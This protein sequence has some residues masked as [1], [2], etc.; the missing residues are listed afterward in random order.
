MDGVKY[1]TP[2]KTDYTIYTMSK[3]KY[4]VMAK[5]HI[6]AMPVASKCININCDKF[7]KTCRDRDN[8]FKF[9]KQYTII[10]YFYFPMIFKN[11][12]FIGGLKELLAKDKKDIKDIKKI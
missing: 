12:K 2:S 4:C 1:K 5:E 11:G 3:C 6:K 8:F 10:P 7:L 9:I